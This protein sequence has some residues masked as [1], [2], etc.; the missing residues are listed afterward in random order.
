MEK[1]DWV[2]VGHGADGGKHDAVLSYEGA[3]TCLDLFDC[4]YA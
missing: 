1:L 4:L 2:D 3:G